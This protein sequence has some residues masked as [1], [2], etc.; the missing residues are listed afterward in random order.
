MKALGQLGVSL[1]VFVVIA[2]HGVT[3]AP[4]DTRRS[5]PSLPEP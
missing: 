1:V 3:G 5:P 2:F 4:L